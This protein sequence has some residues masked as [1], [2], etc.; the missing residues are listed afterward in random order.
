L[1]H[2][3]RKANTSAQI[4]IIIP[5]L[6][7][8]SYIGETLRS[9]RPALGNLPL[10]HEIV[11]VDGASTDKTLECCDLADTLVIETPAERS[12]IARARN[13]GAAN[14]SGEFLFHTDADIYISDVNRFFCYLDK[15]FS[16]ASVVAVTGRIEPYPHAARRR[17]RVWHWIGNAII[18][19]SHLTRIYFARGEFQVVRTSA[20]TAAGGYD[21]KII[22]GE[23]WD[24]F[25]RLASQGKIL[26]ARELVV[27]HSSRR[28][29]AYGYGRTLIIYLRELFFL[30]ILKRS[31]LKKWEE[32][33]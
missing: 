22:V 12:S 1:S 17:D 13:I 15:A 7:E 3:L 16:D 31:Y 21:E 8:S 29:T 32:V 5:A 27:Y 28:F 6:N 24:L 11:V 10:S 26:Y 20:F 2:I 9:L 4:S 19:A 30:V 33:R 25:R 23:D 14:S 18:Y